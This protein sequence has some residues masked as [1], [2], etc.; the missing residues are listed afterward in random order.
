[1]FVGLRD[2]LVRI[3]TGLSLSAVEAR[4]GATR[5]APVPSFVSFAS[6]PLSGTTAAA[7]ANAQS[8]A[9]ED[10][11]TGHYIRTDCATECD[12]G[13]AEDAEIGGCDPAASAVSDTG[14]AKMVDDVETL[15]KISQLQE[16]G[17]QH[18]ADQLLLALY[19]PRLQEAHNYNDEDL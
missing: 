14:P 19:R 1:M 6:P 9:R 13:A 2:Q 3:A 17:L 18:E 8:E 4:S 7:A 16:E 11:H 10:N 5:T 15:K 12:V